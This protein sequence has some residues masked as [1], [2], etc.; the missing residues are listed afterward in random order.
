MK[1]KIKKILSSI[2]I[3]VSS[4]ILPGIAH[5][6]LNQRSKAVLISMLLFA[7]I[8]VMGWTGLLFLPSA[9]WVMIAF[10]SFVYIYAMFDAFIVFVRRDNSSKSNSFGLALIYTLAIIAFTLLLVAKKPLLLGFQLY[11]IPSPSMYPF[12]KPGDLILADTRPFSVNKIDNERRYCIYSW[13]PGYNF[14]HKKSESYCWS[15]C[16]NF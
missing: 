13:K 12:L 7:G 14:L 16:R 4:L 11:I 6:W 1:S 3:L 2:L 8:A 9:F 15:D 5:F 10:I